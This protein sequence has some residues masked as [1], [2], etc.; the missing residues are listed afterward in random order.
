L[1]ILTRALE[2]NPVHEGAVRAQMVVLARMG[3]RSEALARYERLVDDLLD[4]FGTD[5]DAETVALFR[6]LLTGSRVQERPRQPAPPRLA[7][8][9]ASANSVD[10]L[11]WA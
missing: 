3:R 7:K 11:R 6:E 9:S 1:I 2:S 5:P 8:T 4:A 10:Q